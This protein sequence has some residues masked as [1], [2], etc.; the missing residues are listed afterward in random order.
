M[1]RKRTVNLLLSQAILLV[2]FCFR[3]FFPP[4]W[5]SLHLWIE[6]NNGDDEVVIGRTVEKYVNCKLVHMDVYSLLKEKEK[7]TKLK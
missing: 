3:S 6:F 1:K 4:F 2:L 7:P 5:S